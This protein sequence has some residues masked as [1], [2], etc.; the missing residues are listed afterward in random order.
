MPLKMK[1]LT[2][3]LPLLLL[4]ATAPAVAQQTAPRPE[5]S[6]V[7]FTLRVNPLGVLNKARGQAEITFGPVGVGV[8]G[9]HYYAGSFVGP[10][11]E[12]YGRFYTGRRLAEGFYVQAKASAGRYACRPTYD[13]ALTTYDSRGFLKTLG[14]ETAVDLGER[15]FTSAG[16]GSGVGYQFRLGGGR[17]LVVD[18]YAG[19]QYL[20]LPA[21]LDDFARIV[22]T[23]RNP[24]G[25]RTEAA[26]TSTSDT[27][28]EWYLLGPGSVFN[29]MAS[30]GYTFGGKGTGQ[31]PRGRRYPSAP[32]APV[33]DAPIRKA[34]LT[35]PQPWARR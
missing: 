9:T 14:S 34:A 19:L 20:P 25:G 15:R 26:Y 3:L 16:G 4:A 32:A 12:L 18:A 10:K 29:G 30:I 5:T 24:D 28:T 17:R 21:D 35:Q 22:R 27:S 23:T 6:P 8:V 7:V 1:L 11:A 33:P 13:L 31:L 2:Q